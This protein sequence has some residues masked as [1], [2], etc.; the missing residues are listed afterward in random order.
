MEVIG[1]LRD[2][3]TPPG[4]QAGGGA[5]GSKWTG[6]GLKVIILGLFF[7]MASFIAEPEES[8]STL[9]DLWPA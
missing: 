9:S 4:N 2:R 8:K 5:W 1:A 6:G 3:L 7:R